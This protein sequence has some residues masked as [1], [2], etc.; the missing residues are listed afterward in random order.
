MVF[1][2][3]KRKTLAGACTIS[4]AQAGSDDLESVCRGVGV[5]C[6][7]RGLMDQRGKRRA[8]ERETDSGDRVLT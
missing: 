1:F 2:T 4:K 5:G 3:T 6:C 8:A 7:P